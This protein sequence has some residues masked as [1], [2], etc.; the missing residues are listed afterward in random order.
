MVE[1]G[2]LSLDDPA[3]EYVPEIADIQVLEGFDADGQ[4]ILRAPKTD[5]TLNHLMLHTSGLSYEFFSEDDLK[6]RELKEIP[7]IISST[8]DSIKSVLLYDPGERWGYGVSLDWIGKIV[9]AV[10][11]KRLDEVMKERIFNPL[12]MNESSFTLTPS[13]QSRLAT[14]HQR[15]P[16]GQLTAMELVLPQPPEMDMGG[17]GLYTTIGD[18][19]KFIRMILNDGAGPNARVLKPETVKQMS[20]NGLGELKCGAWVSSIPSLVNDGEIFP[21]LQKSWAYTFM[22]NEEEAPT[23]RPANQLMWVGATNLFFW[24]DRHNGI[25][26]MWGTQILPFQDVASYPG[27]ID[28][29]TAVYKHL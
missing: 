3:K 22:V 10:R 7:T 18:Y 17:H 14:I 5:I 25:G 1:E 20:K 16:D 11:G 8:F 2:L 26:G 4:A 24:I 27:Y 29:E 28:F 19:M 12:D 9:E 13:M 21:G 6:Y 15:A 23:G